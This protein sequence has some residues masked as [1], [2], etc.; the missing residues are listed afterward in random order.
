M[1]DIREG[2]RSN[3]HGGRSDRIE[4]KKKKIKCE[5]LE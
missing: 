2:K 5:L 3:G 1:R 4:K